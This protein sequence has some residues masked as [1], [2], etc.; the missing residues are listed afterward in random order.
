MLFKAFGAVLAAG[1]V[2]P[3]TGIKGM[4]GFAKKGVTTGGL[5]AP[6]IYIKNIP[7]LRRYLTDSTPR[8]LVIT[9]NLS[10][11]QKI[12]LVMGSNKSI[13]GS[14]NE[15]LINNIYLKA[16]PR[17]ENIIFQNL[18]FKHAVENIDN[19]DTQLILDY[20]QRYWIDHCTFD[21]A[22][23]NKKDLGKLLKVGKVDY[24]SISN[25]KFM[26]HEYG[27]LL[28]YPSDDPAGLAE[29][30]NFPQITIM[31]NY[32]DNI[33]ARAPG[34]M[35]YGKFHVFNNYI[36]N[37]HLGFTISYQS[38]IYSE[39]NYFS[40]PSENFAVLDDKGNGYFKDVGSVSMPKKQD[41][42]LN[43]WRPS[44]DYRYKASNKPDYSRDFCIKYAGIQ[45]KQLVFGGY[46]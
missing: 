43:T 31:Y 28:G 1:N 6:V 37:C 12:I 36:H 4:I 30:N 20:G 24:V 41:S 32:F 13:I 26:N 27:L 16:S 45:N 39:Y 14:W 34:L 19:G 23:V 44:T 38:K 40:D 11:P 7:D 15:N 33:N 21:G 35:R 5:N 18:F 46:A 9:K 2:Y 3:T 42:K 25:C 17:S 29:Y 10:S 8:T 22:I